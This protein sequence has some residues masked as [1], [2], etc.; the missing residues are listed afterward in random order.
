MTLPN[1]AEMPSLQEIHVGGKATPNG[2]AIPIHI[3]THIGILGYAFS[4]ASFTILLMR[5]QSVQTS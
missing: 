2:D 5:V 3:L 1:N 4:S